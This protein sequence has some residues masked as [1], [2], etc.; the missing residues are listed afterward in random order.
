MNKKIAASILLT[1]LSMGFMGAAQA[2][3]SLLEKNEAALYTPLRHTGTRWTLTHFFALLGKNDK[4]AAEFLVAARPL[5]PPM[6]HLQLAAPIRSASLVKT[7]KREHS[8]TGTARCRAL[9]SSSKIPGP[10]PMNRS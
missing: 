5:I 3:P 1:C 10:L 7:G 4:E 8:M 6:E 2:F 9:R